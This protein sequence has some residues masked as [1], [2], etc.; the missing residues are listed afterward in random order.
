MKP[1]AKY[2]EWEGRGVPVRLEV[3]P[4][5]VEKGQ[6]VL[7]R[8]TGGKAPVALDGIHAAVTAA[9][10][11]IQRCLLEAARERREANSERGVTKARLVEYMEGGGGFAYGGFC[12]RSEC[13]AAVKAET[14]ATI[15]LLP[16][17][18]FRSDPAPTTCAWCGG[19]ASVEAVWARA[20]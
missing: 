7:A 15:R 6:A 20:Y 16:D 17:E 4:K 14:K 9:L 13:E 10:A 1:G 8:R 2:Y 18:E 3:G 5:D 19:P 11:D 12:G